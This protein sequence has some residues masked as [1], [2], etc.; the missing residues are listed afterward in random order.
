MGRLVALLLVIVG[1]GLSACGA[2]E[3]LVLLPDDDGT[4]GALSIVNRDGTG[5]AIIMDQAHQMMLVDPAG[6]KIMTMASAAVMD[7]EFGAVLD[8]LPA[9]GKTFILYFETASTRVTQESQDALLKLFA[10]VTGRQAVEVLVTGHTDTVGEI[11]TNDKLAKR[12]AENVREM[13][14][15]R[16]LEASFIWAA[17][18]GERDLLIPTPDETPEPRNRRVEVIVR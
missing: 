16:G 17:G 9:P 8:S 2:R 13:L 14:L 12:R 5:K 11:G 4:I 15:E 10:E 1:L 6:S 7:K 18:R 3:I